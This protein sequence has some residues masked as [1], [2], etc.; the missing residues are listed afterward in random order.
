MYTIPPLN[1][2][3]VKKY[4][5]SQTEGDLY[6]YHKG[7]STL[8]SEGYRGKCIVWQIWSASSHLL[9]CQVWWVKQNVQLED[10]LGTRCLSSK[11]FAIRVIYTFDML[12]LNL[13]KSPRIGLDLYG[14]RSTVFEIDHTL[15]VHCIISVT[16]LSNKYSCVQMQRRAFNLGFQ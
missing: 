11:N 5:L 3:V 4:Q 15:T 9:I 1:I 8:R 7:T 6:F 14:P 2:H 16:L 12:E 13:Q 10:S